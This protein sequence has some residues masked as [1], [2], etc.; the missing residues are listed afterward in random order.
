MIDIAVV[1]PVPELDIDRPG[2]H[3]RDAEQV[4]EWLKQNPN[5]HR[6][7]VVRDFPPGGRNAQR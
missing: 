2:I 7:V 5:D 6:V 4:A 1:S 3:K